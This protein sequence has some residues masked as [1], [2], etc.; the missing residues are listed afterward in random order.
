[1]KTTVSAN[2]LIIGAGPAGIAAV[3]RLID[4]GISPHEI[5]W[6][7]PAFKVGDFGEKWACVSSNTKVNLF[8]RFLQAS[9]A[10]NY[11]EAPHDFALNHLTPSDTCEL[12]FM[13]EPLQWVSNH[14]G[15]KV[16]TKVGQVAHLYMGDHGWY[17]KLKNDEILH[18]K[19]VII[20]NGAEPKK[21]SHPISSIDLDISLNKEKLTEHISKDNNIAVFGSSHSSIIV[22]QHLIE[23][24]VKKIT[25]FYLSPLRYAVY[26]NQDEILF[27]DTGLKG[28]TAL[29]ARKHLHGKLPDNLI[30]LI[31]NEEN[32]QQHLPECDKAIYTIGFWQRLSLVIEGA[33]LRQYNQHNGIIAPGLFG[34]GIGFPPSQEDR[35]GHIEHR[36][37]LWKF[38][39]YL[40]EILPIWLA[41]PV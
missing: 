41:Y 36:V 17:A 29:W 27:D 31:G 1:M 37:G 32:L 35:F 23:L 15:E 28:S 33:E 7:D 34:F 11:N 10:F 4:H 13:V 30:R 21:L 16:K 12:S 22:M 40:N 26:L 38:M 19:N 39:H 9:Q 6:V 3:G 25:N 5:I 14:L 18:V 24:G 2:W 20:A 8:T